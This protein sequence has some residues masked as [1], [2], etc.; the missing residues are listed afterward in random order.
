[1]LLCTLL[2]CLLCCL[3]PCAG[4]YFP[5]HSSFARRSLE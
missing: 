3:V 1:L 5:P 2:L 4:W